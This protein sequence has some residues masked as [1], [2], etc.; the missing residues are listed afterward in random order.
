MAGQCDGEADVRVSVLLHPL[1]VGS[2]PLLWRDWS[3]RFHR[4]VCK[5]RLALSTGRGVGR[6]ESVCHL[7]PCASASLA[8]TACALPPRRSRAAR[9]QCLCPNET[10][11]DHALWSPRKLCHLDG[12]GNGVIRL[13]SGWNSPL[14]G[15]ACFSEWNPMSSV[16]DFSA[17]FPPFCLFCAA[18]FC[19]CPLLQPQ[20]P[21]LRRFHSSDTDKLFHNLVAHFVGEANNT[22]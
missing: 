7:G 9:S 4:R 5:Q 20:P 8:C 6:S 22:L 18:P 21:V 14:L 2:Q 3:R 1:T 19:R 16:A 10:G 13:K 12:F 15:Q 11:H 17:N